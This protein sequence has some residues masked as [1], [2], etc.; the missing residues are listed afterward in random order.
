MNKDKTANEKRRTKKTC[1]EQSRRKVW[2]ITDWEPL[3]ELADDIRKKRSGPLTYTK[4][5]VTISGLSTAAE[6]RHYEMMKQLK[7]RPER[8][9]LRSVL[10]D[11][12]NWT[13]AKHYGPRGY[14]V[15]T[16]N[17]PP[18]LDYIAAQLDKLEAK[19]LEIAMPILEDIGL[20]EKV[21]M[22]GSLEP[23]GPK[24]TGPDSSGR[25]RTPLKKDKDKDKDK[26]KKKKKGKVDKDNNNIK[27]NSRQE[28]NKHKS[29]L[30][31]GQTKAQTTQA[32]TTTPE[33]IKSKV[34]EP[35]GSRI[36]K[37]NGPPGSVKY[38]RYD[39]DCKMFAQEIFY[40]LELEK[41]GQSVQT[42]RNLGS[43]ASQW[44]KACRSGLPPP[45]LDELRS[46]AITEARRLGR[47]YRNNKGNPAAVFNDVFND[48]LAK[49]IN[50]NRCKAM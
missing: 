49:R 32:P 25:K 39:D 9:L 35:G 11:L 6:V 36:I 46:S 40:G 48:K 29:H 13:G 34:V 50:E 22:N 8:H 7:A 12:T 27:N 26:N 4:S 19:D 31:E 47:Y 44:R 20:I 1:P 33:S 10:E 5:Q 30:V 41:Q 23:S 3:Y 28:N 17:K 42:R 14:L 2:R 15:T 18:S 45:V 21:I 43:F 16:E 24:R 38:K 37:F